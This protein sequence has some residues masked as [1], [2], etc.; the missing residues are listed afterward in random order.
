MSAARGLARLAFGAAE[1]GLVP[2]PV[3]RFGARAL[4]HRRLRS[5]R[6]APRI[7]EATLR[8]GLIAPAPAAANRQH[9]E[10]P[11]EFYGLVLGAARKYSCALWR[12]EV[13]TLDAAELAMLDHTARMA[14][15]GP[16]QDV[17][18]LGCGWG[19][20]S[21]FAAERFP[22]SRFLAVS[23]SVS[24]RVFIEREA[25]AR[26]L[27][28]LEVLT[29]DVNG[30][31]LPPGRFDRIVSVEMFE[32]MSNYAELMRRI[33]R[34]LTPGGRLF[35]HVFC[36]RRHAYRFSTDGAGDWMGREFFTGG[37]M[38]SFD[39]LPRF[40][41]DLAL[42]E[43]RWWS[44][45]H[46]RKTAEAWLARLDARREE[47]RRV[48]ADLHGPEADR[49]VERW[50][51]FFIGCAETFGLRGGSE[52]GIGHYRFVR[53]RGVEAVREAPAIELARA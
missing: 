46:Y 41:G 48:L 42:E 32:H 35:V 49:H 37:L 29:A 53:P 34:W 3:L 21:L 6:G 45:R 5:L 4:A 31:Q 30:L 1:R 7:D 28:N 24:Q 18:D 52:W 22:G 12:P 9:Y 26:G 27:G 39:L 47:V 13:R 38:P 33:T 2:D 19:A 17:L 23:N 8:R 40:A 16:G 10:V 50:R 15:I 14:G 43:T 11:A 51:L 25:D 36:H 44:G 20:F